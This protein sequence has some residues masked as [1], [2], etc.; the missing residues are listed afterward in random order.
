[1][2]AIC[3]AP[4]FLTAGNLPGAQRAPSNNPQAPFKIFGN[5][6][7]VG[8]RGVGSVLVAT[9]AG[10]ALID[11]GYPESAAPIIE[12]IRQLGFRVDDVRLIV[13]SH[14][15]FDPQAASAS[16]NG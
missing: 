4:A 16:C 7:Y 1:M 3:L 13:N 2:R 10:H 9:A 12:S 5:T 15:H 14:V 11:G 6:Y 8:P